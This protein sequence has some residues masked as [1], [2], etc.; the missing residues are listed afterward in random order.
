MKAACTPA[1]GANKQRIQTVK[2]NMIAGTAAQSSL[3]PF[4]K[5]R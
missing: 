4:S 2:N 5:I 1:G 3:H